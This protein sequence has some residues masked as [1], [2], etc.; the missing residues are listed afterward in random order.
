M[1][2]ARRIR[3][4]IVLALSSFLLTVGLVEIALRLFIPLSEQPCP[5]FDADLGLYREPNQTGTFVVGPVGQVRG[6]YRINGAGWNSTHE[7]TT[8][9]PPG[10]Y[11]IVVIGDSMV[12]ALQVDFDQAYPEVVEANL[13]ASPACSHHERIEVYRFGISGAPFSHYLS[14]MR[15]TAQYA[16]DLYIIT[17]ISNDF[18]QSIE[19][20]G[21]KYFW[22][23][24]MNTDGSIEEVPPVPFS[25]PSRVDQWRGDNIAILRYINGNLMLQT[26]FHLWAEARREREP[27]TL[28]QIRAEEN[29]IRMVTD[30]SIREYLEVARS[31]ESDLLLVMDTDREAIHTGQPISPDWQHLHSLVNDAAEEVGVD[32]ID[33]TEAFTEDFETHGERLGFTVD[34]HWNSHGHD[35]VAETVSNWIIDNGCGG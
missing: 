26:R 27:K 21:F 19:G 11:R 31:H 35:V 3:L 18:D 34:P 13:A 2:R 16:P 28:E 22:K 29:A 23:Y 9:K 7:F 14:L 25:V 5:A 15:H 8:E 32:V 30:Y 10:V 12:E 20:Q 24:R 6:E 17:I 33:L 4:G 1:S